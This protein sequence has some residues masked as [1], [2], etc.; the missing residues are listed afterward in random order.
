MADEAVLAH[1]T[2]NLL[3]REE[4]WK[5]IINKLLDGMSNNGWGLVHG[6]PPFFNDDEMYEM[7]R[8]ATAGRPR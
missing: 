1:A 8:E 3:R 5:A 6:T 7:W 2:Q 4:K